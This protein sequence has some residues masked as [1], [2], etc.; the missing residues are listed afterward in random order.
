LG[1]ADLGT[2]SDFNANT[3]RNVASIDTTKG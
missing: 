1:I 3:L 2:F